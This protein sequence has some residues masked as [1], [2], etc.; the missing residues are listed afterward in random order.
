MVGSPGYAGGRC[1]G[2]DGGLGA[3]R[4]GRARGGARPRP[5][6]GAA[7]ACRARRPVRG[8]RR[9]QDGPRPAIHAVPQYLLH[10]GRQPRGLPRRCP[11]RIG[12]PGGRWPWAPGGRGRTAACGLTVPGLR[13]RPRL[14]RDARDIHAPRYPGWR[15]HAGAVTPGGGRMWGPRPAGRPSPRPAR[16]PRACPRPRPH[17]GPGRRHRGGSGPARR[18]GR[19]PDRRSTPGRA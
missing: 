13:S 4:P 12:E 5:V 3:G 6:G 1:A 19:R 2:R 8:R 18:A 11:Q 16:A 17:P 9:G 7:L 15:A 14:R 10:Y